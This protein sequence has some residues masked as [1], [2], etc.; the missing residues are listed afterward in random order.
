MPVSDPIA[1]MLTRIRNA[2]LAKHRRVVMPNSK[3]LTAIAKI[4]KEEGFIQNYKIIS[5]KPQAALQIDLKY[6]KERHPQPVIMGL[7][8]VSKPGRRIYTKQ[9]DIPWVRS[10]LG[11]AI[12]STSKGVISDRKAR[13][14]GIGGEI[15]C[16]VW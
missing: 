15:L 9:D 8:R 4:L 5:G 3:M 14:L 12:L 2:N 6:T 7:T 13:N 11:V 10:G 16:Y 1:D